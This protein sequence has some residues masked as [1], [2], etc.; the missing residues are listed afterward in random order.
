MARYFLEVMYDGTAF[1]GSQLQGDEP[2]VQL[3]VNNA[4]STL[5]RENITSYGASRTD[6][7]VHALCNYY[8]FDT[9]TGLWPSF[10]YNINAILPDAIAV[11]RLLQPKDNNMNARFAATKRAYRYRIYHKKDPFRLNKALH[12]PYRIDEDI[13]HETA[14]ILKEYTN[15]ESFS[16][17][18]TQS[19]T[20]ECTIYESYWERREDELHYV[21]EANRFLRGMVRALTGTQLLAARGKLT[22]EAFRQVILSRDCSQADFGIAGYGLYLERI[23][24]PADTLRELVFKTH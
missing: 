23:D 14:S 18:N 7:D 3:A 1:K 21:V 20:F 12:Y 5:L 13:L 22:T 24:Y 2:T 15:F 4:L 9:E 8:H 17:R 10:I 11:K 19:K 6:T 16:K